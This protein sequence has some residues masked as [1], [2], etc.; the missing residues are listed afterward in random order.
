MSVSI[1]KREGTAEP[2]HNIKEGRL[3]VTPTFAGKVLECNNY[4]RQRPVSATHVAFLAE[5]MR[6][7]TF[8]P[9]TQL[10]FARLGDHLILTNGQHRLQAVVDSG[11]PAEFQI[12]IQDMDTPEQV[13]AAY[14]TFDRGGRAR[15]DAD[16]L[17]SAGICDRFGIPK[18]FARAVFQGYP[19]LSGKFHRSNYLTDATS[20]NDDVRLAGLESWWP[21]AAAFYRHLEGAPRWARARL[22]SGQGVAVGAV[23]IKYQPKAAE[24][25]WHGL[26]EDD[27]LAKGDPRKTLLADMA[28][29]PWGRR[30][31]DGCIV[32][33]SAWNAFFEGRPLSHIKVHGNSAVRLAGTPVG[34]VR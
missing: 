8:R 21:H 7:G 16:V 28:G 33:A 3:V 15:C 30:G 4:E 32:I 1:L 26:A 2:V 5:H 12:L 19:L 23:T 11:R 20:R 10:A 24:T 17:E 29:R 18:Q 27:G 9:G 13:A 34:R 6:R 25:F 31:V 22:F 14:Y